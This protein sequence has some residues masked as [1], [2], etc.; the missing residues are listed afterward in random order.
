MALY[1]RRISSSFKKD[2]K[3]IKHSPKICEK[4]ETAQRTWKIES[5]CQTVSLTI[6]YLENYHILESVISS[7]MCYLYTRSNTKNSFS[8]FSEYDHIVSYSDN[9]I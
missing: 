2:Y 7:L 1:K 6:N 8:I 3:A 4:L 5:S 9:N